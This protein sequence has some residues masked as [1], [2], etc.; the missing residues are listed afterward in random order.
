MKAE[1]QSK[2]PK[3]KDELRRFVKISF[4]GSYYISEDLQEAVQTAIGD[5]EDQEIGDCFEIEV[6]EMSQADFEAL[7]EF[8]GW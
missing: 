1:T 5:I 6:I 3:D 4:D 2:Q 7:P 8:D